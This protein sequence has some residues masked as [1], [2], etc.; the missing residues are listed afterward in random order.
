M[1]YYGPQEDGYILFLEKTFMLSTYLAF[2]GYGVQ[3]VMFWICAS[4]LWRQRK[5]QGKL[6]YFRLTYITVLFL[7]ESLV[8]ASSTWT[9]ESMF[10]RNRNYPGGPVAWFL[11]SGNVPLNVAF[12]GSF[13][14]LTFMSDLLVLWRCWVIWSTV[15]QLA[16]FAILTIPV[17]TL[18][19]SIV[20][21]VMWTYQSSQPGLSMYSQLAVDVGTAYYV[22]SLGVNVVL[23]AL[24]ILRL[25]HLRTVVLRILPAD[26]TKHYMSVVTIVVESVLVYSIFALAF[27]I[28]YALN[29]PM[30]QVF[31]Y[32]GSACQQIAG[33]MIILRVAQGRAWTSDTEATL[34]KRHTTMRL[35]P[36]P[37]R[38]PIEL[39]LDHSCDKHLILKLDARDPM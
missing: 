16:A 39:R 24:I 37:T 10:I 35:E 38:D 8:M 33:Y 7:L 14:I 34:S 18:L 1:P 6:V 21:G 11:A 20:L 17:L 26:Y 3:V 2:I 30:N 22:T 32:M 15:G 29:N 31:L 25:V 36:I 4:Y 5:C 9:I 13:F 27:I 23:T 12:F 19:S 28:T